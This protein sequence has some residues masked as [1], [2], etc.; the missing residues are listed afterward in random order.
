MLGAVTS[1]NI[2]NSTTIGNHRYRA[3][4]IIPYA[5]SFFGFTSFL[6]KKFACTDMFGP[7]D[8]GCLMTFTSRREGLSSS[9]LSTIYSCLKWLI[10][11]FLFKMP[12][13]LAFRT[14]DETWG[15]LGPVRMH[16]LLPCGTTN[17]SLLLWTTI[18]IVRR[19]ALFYSLCLTLFSPVP[20]YDAHSDPFLFSKEDFVRLP[21]LPQ[22]KKFG[23]PKHAD[24][25]P[26]ALVTV[27]FTLNT[28]ASTRAPPTPGSSRRDDPVAHS[29]QSDNR[30]GSSHVLSPN[31][32]FLLYHGLIPED[33]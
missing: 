21:S 33:D 32:Q 28:Y 9:C 26:N 8:F 29:S 13:H 19:L 18:K 23:D 5:P 27:F 17:N 10:I 31:L 14:L 3:I 12:L 24:L 1:C 22:Y 25:P 2:I 11:D 7:F 16:L 30:T 15:R 20:I 4:T 6:G